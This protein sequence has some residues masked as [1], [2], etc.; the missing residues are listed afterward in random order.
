MS[1]RERDRLVALHKARKRLIT[2]RQAAEELGLSERQVRRLLRGLRRRGDRAVQHGLRGRPSNR[3]LPS[4]L[5]RQVVA[6]LRAATYRGFGPTL[7]SEHLARDHGVQLGRESLRG[8]M[9][10]AG[11]WR[12][13]SRR[14]GA[15]HLWR[16]RRE[17]FG[18]LVQWDT[19]THDWLEGRGPDLK[20]IHLIDDATSDLMAR[21]VVHDGTRE[22]LGMLESWIKSFGRMV[23]VYPDRGSLFQVAPKQRRDDLAGNNA[24]AA[25]VTQIGRALEELG[26]ELILARSP[27]AKGR[28]ERSFKTAQDRLVKELRVAGACTL[29][30]ANHVLETVFLPWW[31]RHCRRPP[32]CADNAHR[33]LAPHHDLA[34]AL[35]VVHHAKVCNDYTF[36]FAGG[37]YRILRPSIIAGLRGSRVRIEAR[38]DGSLRARFHGRC[39][40][41][42]P[43]SLP[44]RLPPAAATSVP[45]P[46][47]RRKA[48]SSWMRNFDLRN[49]PPLWRAA[50]DRPA[51]APLD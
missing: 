1:Q 45:A 29:E 50:R 18:E 9:T 16:P 3:K 51:P 20:L 8:L 35:S 6:I 34:A 19:S 44:P 10:A 47:P 7:A 42:G 31:R 36:R 28:V 39:L 32:A 22:N 40:E 43:A 14:Q 2:Q 5:R 13:R 46:R 17:R 41:F 48:R 12:P 15:V 37:H 21:F 4:S 33:P 11:L 27:Q 30:E 49:A 38:A 26:I 25:G 24:S 23:A